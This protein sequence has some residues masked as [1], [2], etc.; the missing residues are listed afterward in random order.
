MT[1]SFGVQGLE[2]RVQRGLQVL[3]HRKPGRSGESFIGLEEGGFAWV[4]SHE[5]GGRGR[6]ST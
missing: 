1:G 6:S 3:G 5:E 2:V 4:R